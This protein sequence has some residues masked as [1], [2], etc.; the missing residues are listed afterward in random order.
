MLVADADVLR[1]AEEC[2]ADPATTPALRR[3]L[4]DQVDDLRR[5]LKVREPAV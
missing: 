4:A 5:L 2:L 3:K 1:S